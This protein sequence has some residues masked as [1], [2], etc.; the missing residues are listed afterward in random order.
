MVVL[1]LGD[2]MSTQKIKELRERTGAG[3]LDCKKSLEKANGDLDQALDILRTAGFKPKS[4][5]ISAEGSVFSYVDPEL[6]IG[7]LVEVNC[8]TDF[9]ARTTVFLEFGKNVAKV[10][11]L[12]TPVDVASLTELVRSE[13]DRVLMATKENVV[14]RRFVR[15]ELGE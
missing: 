9:V 11:V 3:I 6:Q 8:E 13:L 14:V 7:S 4:G 2:V 10:A 12:Q 1:A 5:R 15:F